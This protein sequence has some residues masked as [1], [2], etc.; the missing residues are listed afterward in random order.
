M[1]IF[2]FVVLSVI[3]A[4][5]NVLTLHKTHL[6]IVHLIYVNS[7]WIDAQKISQE[8]KGGP[9]PLRGGVEAQLS[10]Q[11]REFRMWFNLNKIFASDAWAEMSSK[12][13]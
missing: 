9:S 6:P 1:Q 13:L 10:P 2:D 3:L 8:K 4:P 11:R 5:H 12:E 7:N